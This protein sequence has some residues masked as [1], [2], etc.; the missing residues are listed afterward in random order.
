MLCCSK[1]R[2][3]RYPF[4]FRNERTDPRLVPDSPHKCES[5]PMELTYKTR[6]I[7]GSLTLAMTTALSSLPGWACSFDSQPYFAYPNHPEFPLKHYA[8]GSLAVLQ[9]GYARSYLLVAH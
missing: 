9:P 7:V 3:I 2:R 4:S 8:A 5:E 6:A 1:R